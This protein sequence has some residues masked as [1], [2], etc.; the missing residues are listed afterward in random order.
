M[1]KLLALLLALTLICPA[2]AEP[3]QEESAPLTR[4]ELEIYADALVN[5]AL[6]K[7]AITVVTSQDGPTVAFT[8]C[9]SLTIADDQLT[10]TTALLDAALAVGQA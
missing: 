5:A 9:G 10:Q 3:A 7:G 4:E 1:K 8:G 2:L 6:E